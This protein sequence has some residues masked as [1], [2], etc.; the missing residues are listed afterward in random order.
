MTDNAGN[1]ETFTS[2]IVKID[3]TNPII[4]ATRTPPNAND[5]NNGNVDVTFTGSDN[6]LGVA[7]LTQP[8]TVSSEGANQ[9]VAGTIVDIAGNSASIIVSNINIDKTRPTL[10]ITTPV[11]KD[12]Y[13]NESFKIDFT[14]GDSLSGIF[15]TIATIGNRTVVNG[16]IINLSSMAGS[17]TLTVTVTDKSGNVQTNSVTFYVVM[18]SKVNIDPNTLNLKSKG[19]S[20]SFT[21]YIELP[22]GYNVNQ[23]NVSTVRLN[24]NGILIAAQ[25]TP[26]S[27]GDYD[28]DGILEVMV[29]FD[30]QQIITA[31]AGKTG[32]ITMIVTGQ[33]KDGRRFNGSDTI[34]VTNPG[35]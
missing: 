12:Y 30:R 31:L 34:K 18:A 22:A 4:T 16:E 32:D 24:V 25:L 14:T 15:T 29:K 17:N 1:V 35:K 21:V 9:S 19:G 20:N 8:V 5:W 6:L 3:K 10:A 26:T 2:Q 7:Y 28:G 13:T 23:I 33:L 27:V 11:A